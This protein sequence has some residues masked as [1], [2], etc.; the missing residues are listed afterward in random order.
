ML[1]DENC[2]LAEVLGETREALSKCDDTTASMMQ[3][4]LQAA[5][6][7]DAY[8]ANESYQEL[9]DLA[10]NALHNKRDAMGDSEYFQARERLVASLI[11]SQQRIAPLV[12]DSHVYSTL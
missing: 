3:E 12:P 10:L 7:L 9:A 11:E 2:A 6:D 5:D 4:R 1:L 8:A